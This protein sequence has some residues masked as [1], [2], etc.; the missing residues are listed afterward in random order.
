[1]SR[2]RPHSSINIIVSNIFSALW[3]KNEVMLLL[4]RHAHVL[5]FSK[6]L[7]SWV[8]A[9]TTCHFQ[10]AVMTISTS[11]SDGYSFRTASEHISMP[12]KMPLWNLN[13]CIGYHDSFSQFILLAS[14]AIEWNFLLLLFLSSYTGQKSKDS[15]GKLMCHLL[16]AL[17]F[18]ALAMNLVWNVT[19][20]TYIFCFY[21]DKI[22]PD[23]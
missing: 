22:S 5:G 19:T 18:G 3:E 12:S 11:C 15:S 2:D 4:Y 7:V 21:K 9:C 6:F 10:A 23:P 16:S 14:T 20:A 1:M 8:L 17:D 13:N